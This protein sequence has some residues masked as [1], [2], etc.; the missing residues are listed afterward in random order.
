MLHKKP[1]NEFV[2]VLNPGQWQLLKYTTRQVLPDRDSLFGTQ[3]RYK[4]R[5]INYYFLR[6]GDK[7]E[8]LKRLNEENIMSVIPPAANYKEWILVNKIELTKEEQVVDFLEFVN[9]AT[10]SPS[11]R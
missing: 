1:V 9:A 6:S 2:Q 10:S 11:Q 5:D 4:F 3:K 8:K 7:V